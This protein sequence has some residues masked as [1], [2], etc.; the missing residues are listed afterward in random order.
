MASSRLQLLVFTSN[1]ASL[2]QLVPELLHFEVKFD[3]AA[4]AI[5]DFVPTKM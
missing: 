3:M 5:L 4:A 1:F 2:P